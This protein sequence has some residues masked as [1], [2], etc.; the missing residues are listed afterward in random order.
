MRTLLAPNQRDQHVNMKMESYRMTEEKSMLPNETKVDASD[1]EVPNRVLAEDI[2]VPDEDDASIS[3]DE[4]EKEDELK[5]ELDD[6]YNEDDIESEEV[7]EKIIANDTDPS[8]VLAMEKAKK[9]AESSPNLWKREEVPH[10]GWH[11][12]GVEDLGAPVGICEMCGYQIIRYAHHM[13]HP[14]YQSLVCGCI[15]AGKMEGNIDEAKRRE[16]DL[17]N[18]LA[19]KENFLKR[20]WKSSKKGNDYLKVDGHVIVIFALKDGKVWKYSI[21]NEFAKE[22]F[23]TREEAVLAVFV[24]LSELNEAS[25]KKKE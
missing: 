22:S 24:K 18:K 15:C 10:Q 17:K 23:K 13:E 3:E 6:V 1:K 5:D 8:L 2:L 9:L 16:A 7:D 20:K 12:V 19:R 21:D 4:F 25:S 14:R 11:C